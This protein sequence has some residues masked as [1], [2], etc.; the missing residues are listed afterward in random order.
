MTDGVIC[1]WT[2]VVIHWCDAFDAENGWTTIAGYKP[3]QQTVVSVGWLWPDCLDGY[4]T[5]VNSYMPDEIEDMKTV[6]MPT[7]IPTQMV[8]KITELVQP[9]AFLP[10]LPVTPDR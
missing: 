10:P 6:G 8:I 3:I 7:H 4:I 2:L 5:I 9:K 1:P